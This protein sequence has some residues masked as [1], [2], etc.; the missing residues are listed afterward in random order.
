[1]KR[2]CKHE[3]QNNI[4]VQVQRESLAANLAFLVVQAHRHDQHGA[5]RIPVSNESAE[6]KL[7]RKTRHIP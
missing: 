7:K 3:E 2:E 6:P 5:Q 4:T 1:M